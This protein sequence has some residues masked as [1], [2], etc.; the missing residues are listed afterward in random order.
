MFRTRTAPTIGASLWRL[1]H[2]DASGEG[3]RPIPVCYVGDALLFKS[4]YGVY[5]LGLLD[6]WGR[7]S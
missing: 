3:R 1:R 2:T 5:L 7:A 4:V 6:G